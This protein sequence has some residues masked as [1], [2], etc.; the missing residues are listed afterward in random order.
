MKAACFPG[1]HSERTSFKIKPPWCHNFLGFIGHA[2][3]I[4]GSDSLFTSHMF[5]NVCYARCSENRRAGKDN[6]FISGPG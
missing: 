1:I 6:I 3:G 2:P 4:G 5:K